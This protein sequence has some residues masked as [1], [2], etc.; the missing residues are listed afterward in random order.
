MLHAFRIN[1]CE[2][3]AAETFE[4]AVEVAVKE[5]GVP[6]EDLVDDSYAT[7][8]PEDDQQLI[9]VDENRDKQMTI[10][11]SLDELDGPGF[12]FGTEY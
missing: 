7:G 10:R 8:E 6:R 3:Y 5:T 1:D 12:A 2:W 11:E 9:Y 4:Q